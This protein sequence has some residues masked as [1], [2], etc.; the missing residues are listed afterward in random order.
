M[1]KQQEIR[2]IQY[3]KSIPESWVITRFDDFCDVTDYVANGSFASLKENV[4]YLDKPGYAILIRI[5]DHTKRWNGNY[6][7]VD[8]SAY[9]FLAKS[10]VVPGDLVIANVGDPGKSFVA[11]DLNMPMT[12]GPNS[13]L[14]KPHKVI[15]A[16]YLNYFYETDWARDLISKITTGTAQKKFN[17][18]GLR[19]TYLPLAPMK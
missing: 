12:L 17:K 15:I 8:K 3:E 10:K 7:Y 6:V 19:T 9:E 5:K 18:T 13:V 1:K 11:P 16:K 14:I 2:S 4:T